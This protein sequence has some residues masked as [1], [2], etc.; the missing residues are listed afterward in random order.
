MNELKDLLKQ[1]GRGFGRDKFF[2]L[3]RDHDM[4]I[5]RKRRYTITT[6]SNHAFYKHTNQLAGA[7]INA[8]DQA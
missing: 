6:N 3:L 4:L 8:P 5:R 2:D 7:T 1:C